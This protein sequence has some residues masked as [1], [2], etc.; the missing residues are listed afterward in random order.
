MMT[1]TREDLRDHLTAVINAAQE[2]PAE[3]RPY[4][5]DTFLD[6]L[7]SQFQLLP[8]SHGAQPVETAS[9]GPRFAGFFSGRG[10]VSV[11][12]MV[13]LSV[14]CLPLLMMSLFVLVHPPVFVLGLM[15]LVFFRFGRRGTRRRWTRPY[16]SRR[17]DMSHYNH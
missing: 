6:E 15:L 11:G 4:L 9:S 8:R 14:L 12:V 1:A 10:P 16:G 17:D 7:E 5:A 13:L 2:L 3:D